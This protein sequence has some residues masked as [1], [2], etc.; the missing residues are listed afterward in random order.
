M[1]EKTKDIQPPHGLARLGF[2]LPI[3]LYRLGLGGLLG[4]RFLLL[5]HTGRKSGL[6]RYTVLEVVRY[7]QASGEC[8][9]ASGWGYKSDWLHNIT[10]NPHVSFQVGKRRADGIAQRLTPE[11]ASEELLDYSR[12]HPFAFH[13]LVRFMGYK[14]DGTQGDTLALGQLLPMFLLKPYKAH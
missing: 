12:K 2:R 8:I 3:G 5:T 6:T 1:P 14:L 10:A 13:E 7:D 9:I 11:E 4:T